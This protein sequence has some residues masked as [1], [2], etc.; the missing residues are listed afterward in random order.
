MIHFDFNPLNLIPIPFY[1]N[2]QISVPGVRGSEGRWTGPY[3]KAWSSGRRLAPVV[4]KVQRKKMNSY[5]QSSLVLFQCFLAFSPFLRTS[6]PMR[7]L[8]SL[9]QQSE[10]FDFLISL[11]EF[12]RF[13]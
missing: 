6:F 1:A 7:V 5:T 3:D 8:Q 11:N 13:F 2:P 4:Q 9:T 10:V 12:F